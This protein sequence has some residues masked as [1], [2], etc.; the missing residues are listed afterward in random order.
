MLIKNA[1][2]LPMTFEDAGFVGDVAVENGKIVGLGKVES[3]EADEI[4]EA[5]GMIVMPAFVNAHTHLSMVLMRNYKDNL[6][7]HEWLGEIFPIEDKLD[8]DDIYYSSVLGC[9]ELIKS[10]C[11]CFQDMYFFQENTAKAVLEAGIKGN[12]G[13]TFFGD[14]EDSK[15]RYKERWPRLAPYFDRERIIVTPAPHAI[16]TTT[17]ESY[18]YARDMARDLGTY[19]HTHLSETQKEVADSVKSFGM[20][21]A[22]YLESLGVLDDITLA[23]CVYL[24]EEETALIAGRNVSVIH[25][26]ISNCKLASGIAK[27]GM[28]KEHGV[29]VALGTDGASSNNNLNMLKE[30]N[31]GLLVNTVSTREYEKRLSAFEMLQ[32][33]TLGGAKALGREK[34]MG[35]IE[36]GKDADL[37]IYDMN[38]INTTPV[39]NPYSAIAYSADKSNIKWVFSG[40]KALLKDG[41]LLTID[42]K[43]AIKNCN[44][45]WQA[46]LGR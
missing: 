7:L 18:L 12:I 32:I 39:N 13:F 23:H 5:G 8:G 10:G 44:R 46:V 22:H 28:F 19:V 14:L 2:V 34:Q 36:V 43:E 16:Y 3:F 35:S 42:E 29:N 4:I 30:L 9:A 31:V 37:V 38:Q 1:L 25:N 6:E 33:A 24:T 27:L 11:T 21:P 45:Q 17:R 26:P 20:T 40:G 15:K 41:K